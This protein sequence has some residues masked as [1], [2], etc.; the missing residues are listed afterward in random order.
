MN[1]EESYSLLREVLPEQNSEVRELFFQI[2]DN[3]HG[4]EEKRNGQI[5]DGEW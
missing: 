1:Q 5:R 3:I 2:L 4:C